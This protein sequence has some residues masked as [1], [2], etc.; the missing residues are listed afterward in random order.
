MIIRRGSL[1]EKMVD[2]LLVL[3]VAGRRAVCWP[4][5]PLRGLFKQKRQRPL[6]HHLVH[7]KRSYNTTN[8][9][10]FHDFSRRSSLS[11]ICPRPAGSGRLFNGHGSRGGINYCARIDARYSILRKSK[12]DA[13]STAVCRWRS[14]ELKISFSILY[15]GSMMFN[16][17]GNLLCLVRTERVRGF[18]RSDRVRN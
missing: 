8:R 1:A 11:L 5:S 3:C 4:I 14:L 9:F 16:T 15:S 13:A 7:L 17:I 6:K 2:I 18:V 10:F 12:E